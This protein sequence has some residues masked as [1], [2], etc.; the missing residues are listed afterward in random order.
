MTVHAQTPAP[1]ALPRQAVR[2]ALVGVEVFVAVGA[3]FGGIG[4]MA[5]NAIHISDDWL[6]GTPF[7][8]W[9]LPGILL[10]LIVAVPMAVAAVAELRRR[11]WAYAASVLAGF[12]QI[13]WI[14]AQ[15][16]IMQRFFILQPIMLT[17][18]TAILLLA[19]MVHSSTR[20]V[21]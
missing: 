8:S 14:I 19:W 12:A 11:A 4:L 18:G 7:N 15:W 1:R 2:W 5:G 9:L 6:I 17:A 16:A 3:I 10:L 20:S 21:V 13:G